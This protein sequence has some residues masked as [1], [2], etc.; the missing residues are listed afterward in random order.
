MNGCKYEWDREISEFTIQVE[1]LQ[2]DALLF[3]NTI[4]QFNDKYFLSGTNIPILDQSESKESPPFGRLRSINIHDSSI[5]EL[6]PPEGSST[7]RYPRGVGNS[8]SGFNLLWAEENIDTDHVSAA[9]VPIVI[10]HSKYLNESWTEPEKVY[11][12][13]RIPWSMERTSGFRIHGNMLY[14]L[15]RSDPPDMRGSGG[16]TF[17]FYSENEWNYHHWVGEKSRGCLY[18][19]ILYVDKKLVMS[20]TGPNQNS[21]YSSYSTDMGSSWNRFHPVVNSLSGRNKAFDAKL[22]RMSDRIYLFW[23]QSRDNRYFSESILY[24]YSDDTGISWSNPANLEVSSNALTFEVAS[25]LN[26]IIHLVYT[27]LNEDGYHTYYRH[28][29]NGN[30]SQERK[31]FID[32]EFD[33]M[34]LSSRMRVDLNSEDVYFT[35]NKYQ[36]NKSLE[37]AETYVVTISNNHVK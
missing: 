21:V 36:S 24:S 33:H 28:F 31:V 8:Q 17:L 5:S 1:R 11:S 15:L 4:S 26:K 10:F 12:S 14:M 23:M 30:W 27:G 35:V 13:F 32:N 18:L 25:D 7:F 2:T 16:L 37:E 19:D 29:N 20:C 6:E 3:N 34:T 9:E 22:I